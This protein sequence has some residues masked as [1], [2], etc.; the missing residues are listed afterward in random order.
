MGNLDIFMPKVSIPPPPH[1][2]LGCGSAHPKP[3]LVG[4][5]AATRDMSFPRSGRIVDLWKWGCSVHLVQCVNRVGGCIAAAPMLATMDSSHKGYHTGQLQVGQNNQSTCKWH[6]P[7]SAA[8]RKR[9]PRSPQ[10][11]PGFLQC[12]LWKLNVGEMLVTMACIMLT[13]RV[14]IVTRGIYSGLSIDQTLPHC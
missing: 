10:A 4:W 8:R 3:L 12:L 2:L 6:F 9:Y 1:N 14:N 13:T 5:R 7:A 11:F